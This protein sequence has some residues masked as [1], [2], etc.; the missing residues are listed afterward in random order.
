MDCINA[1]ILA[2]IFTIVIPDFTTEG[3][4][5]ETFMGFPCIISYKRMWIYNY[6]KVIIKHI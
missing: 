2:V 1:D 4:M 5:G 3:K 6:L